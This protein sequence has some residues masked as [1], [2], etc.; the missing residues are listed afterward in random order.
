M[1]KLLA[2]LLHIDKARAAV[3]NHRVLDAALDLGQI[4]LEHFQ[5]HADAT[6]FTAEHELRIGECKA[7]GLRFQLFAV[8]GLV[9]Q[10]GP[11]IGQIGIGQG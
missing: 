8:M 1:R 9:V 2:R 11:G 4:G 7:V 6:R 5:L 10:L 3:D